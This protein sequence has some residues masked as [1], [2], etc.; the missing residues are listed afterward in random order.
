MAGRKTILMFDDYE[1]EPFEVTNG[2]DQGDPPSSVFYAFYN[3]DLIAPSLNPSEL[4]SAFVDDTAFLVAGNTFQENN[5]KLSDM[6]TR[7]NGA[8]E[9]SISHNS[10][11]EVDKFALLHM[12]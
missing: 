1:S 4:K 3:A 2:L 10:N 12:S 11:F 9:W 7:S 8:T 6:M 5:D